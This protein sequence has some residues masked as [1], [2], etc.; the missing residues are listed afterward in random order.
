MTTKYILKFLDGPL[1][2]DSQEILTVG[3]Y[4]PPKI[5]VM[6]PDKN[7]RVCVSDIFRAI[8]GPLDYRDAKYILARENGRVF[9]YVSTCAP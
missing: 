1:E 4:K 8:H 2:G 3:G 5:L 7:R 6:M 9:S